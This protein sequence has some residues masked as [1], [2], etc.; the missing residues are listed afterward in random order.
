MPRMLDKYTMQARV[1]PALIVLLPLVLA[2]VV[3]DPKFE[4][5][6]HLL[7]GVFVTMGAVA[8]LAHIARVA[9]KGAERSLLRQWGGLPSTIMLR[10]SDQSLNPANKQ[11]YH[12]ALG[13]L[14]PGITIPTAEQ[15]KADPVAADHVYEA[16]CTWLRSQTIDDHK[17]H[18][19]FAENMSY[20]FRRNLYGLRKFATTSVIIGLAACGAKIWID[21]RH[22]AAPAVTAI[23]CLF[24]CVALALAFISVLRST[25]VR[26]AADDYAIRLLAA[27]DELSDIKP[28]KRVRK[29]KSDAEAE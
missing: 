27:I 28:K 3:W 23:I 13:G 4:D 6:I 15:E 12:D 21:V 20:G 11:R 18:R 17:F 29:A 16:C 8:L 5:T 1:I 9:G 10:H 26:A 7:G 22:H 19:L 2:A 14:V 24:C 25:S